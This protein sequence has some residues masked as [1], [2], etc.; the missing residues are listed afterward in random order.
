MQVTLDGYEPQDLW[1]ELKP[2][3]QKRIKFDLKKTSPMVGKIFVE[4][5][6]EDARVRILNIKPKFFQGME[7]EPGRY[8]VEVSAEG[9][10]TEKRWIDIKVGD[11]EQFKFD[12]AK[13]TV[14][15]PISP[16]PVEQEQPVAIQQSVTAP[17]K[18][19]TNTIG[20]EFVLIPAGRFKM[21]S[22]ISPEEVARRYGGKTEWFKPEHPQHPAEI[23]KSFYLQT[24]EVTH[25]QWKKVMQDNTSK[26]KDCGGDCPV[27]MVSWDKIQEFIKKLSDIEGTDKYR[28]PTE[29]EWEYASRAGTTTEFS[30][31]DDAERLGE[32]AWFS[33]NSD[34]KTHPVGSK[35]P[36]AWGLYDMYGNVWEWVE[37][38]WHYNYHGA[39]SDGRA[40]IDEPR[41]ALR[42]VRGGG[43]YGFAQDCRTASRFL[44]PH[45]RDSNF[46]GFRLAR[47]ATLIP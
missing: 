26:F 7:L 1:I 44:T 19:F 11:E 3:E 37:D 30:F 39:P 13:I 16:L 35:K 34:G 32:Y 47:S 2:G 20:M 43:G 38:D 36:N 24:T 23:T 18:R 46:F 9:Y 31:G 45:N 25:R 5:V 41:S 4:T 21:G 12:L 33:K 17:L 29:A 27:V 42:V 10:E 28:F 40:W 8:Y 14:D 15:E 22:G 6:P